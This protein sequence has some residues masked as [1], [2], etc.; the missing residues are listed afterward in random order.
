MKS[1]KSCLRLIPSLDSLFQSCWQLILSRQS[2]MEFVAVPTYSKP[3]E[4]G[5]FVCKCKSKYL[6]FNVFVT[7]P[8]D[9]HDNGNEIISSALHLIV[10]PMFLWLPWLILFLINCEQVQV[11][12][13]EQRKLLHLDPNELNETI[14]L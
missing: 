8:S 2:R 4:M 6:P 1:W 14:R 10:C 7:C 5:N 12:T 9:W 3:M 11:R 13:V